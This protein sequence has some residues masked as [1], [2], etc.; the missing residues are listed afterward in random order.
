MTSGVEVYGTDHERSILLLHGSGSSRLMWLPQLRAL[1]DEFRTIAI[2]MPGHGV[3]RD[4]PFELDG[5]AIAAGQ[6]I[7]E[8]ASGRAVVVG[9]SVGGYVALALADRAPHRVAGLVLSGASASYRGLGGLSTRLYGSFVRVIAKRMEGKA[10]ASM[11]MRLPPDLADDILAEPPSMR[12]AVDTLRRLPGRDYYGMAAR[13]P[14]PILL[15][16]GERDKVN[17]KE[18]AAMAAAG[19]ARVEMV[20]DAGHA[21]SLTQPEAFSESVR[22]FVRQAFA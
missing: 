2:D 14:G 19:G 6:A 16:N 7:D 1:S 15:L 11:R 9:L 20:A 3:H 17:R 12:G 13:Y 18:E 5:A 21:C 10:E 22:V 4:E 8:L